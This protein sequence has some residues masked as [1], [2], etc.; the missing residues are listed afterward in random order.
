M[1]LNVVRERKKGFFFVFL[2]CF[3]FCSLVALFVCLFLLVFSTKQ[4][5]E[6]S[7][8]PDEVGISYSVCGNNFVSV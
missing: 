1:S 2:F 5:P 3:V 7:N 6:V 8:W 4:G